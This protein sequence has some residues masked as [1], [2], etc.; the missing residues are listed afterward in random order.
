MRC[1]MA[2]RR[3]R[4]MSHHQKWRF[5][6]ETTHSRLVRAGTFN[7]NRT[8]IHIQTEFRSQPI[9]WQA[10]GVW[11]RRPEVGTRTEEKV[12]QRDREKRKNRREA[13]EKKQANTRKKTLR[14][15][16]H[17]A[18]IKQRGTAIYIRANHTHPPN[19]HLIKRE[20]RGS[21]SILSIAK[22]PS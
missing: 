11:P 18:L 3:P 9:V 1:A 21:Y 5:G 13:R 12:K 16:F 15:G 10:S 8:H 4:G 19:R 14:T 17:C 7:C 2:R 6:H 20:S 22:C